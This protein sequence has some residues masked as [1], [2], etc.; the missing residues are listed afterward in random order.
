MNRRIRAYEEDLAYIHDVGFGGFARG[1][2]P[3]LI[4]I[5]H[6]SGIRGGLVVDLGCG[7]G[8]LARS[9]VNAGYKVLGIDIS[10][11]ML[12]ISRKRVPQ[13][14]FVQASLHRIDL[15]RCI[16]VTSIGECLNYSVRERAGKKLLQ[17]T[18][19]RIFQALEPGGVFIFDIAEPS[20]ALES[21][22]KHMQGS[23]WAVLLDVKSQAGGNSIDR[24]IT[25]FRKVGRLYRK[26]EEVHRLQLWPRTSIAKELRLTG[27]RVRLISGYG[28][29]PFPRGIAGFLARRPQ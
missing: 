29:H 6:E 21:S 26:S 10:A 9:L 20:R 14:R 27:F 3:A 28:E 1:A 23:D 24:R 22:R 18:L 12:R 4:R 8:I 19:R 5:L 25:T 17:R 2:A 7:S 15:P 16:C 11:A 13:G